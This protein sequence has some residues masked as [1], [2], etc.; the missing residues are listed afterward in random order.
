MLELIAEDHLPQ[1]KDDYEKSAADVDLASVTLFH[2]FQSRR[3]SGA[4]ASTTRIET[5]STK[6][7][8]RFHVIRVLFVRS[9]TSVVGHDQPIVK[10]SVSEQLDYE[11]ELAL[12]IGKPGRHIQRERAW[13]HIFGMTLCNEGASAIGF[14]TGSS[15]SRKG[16]ILTDQDRSGHGLSLRTS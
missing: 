9:P 4:S 16:K 5:K 15:M 13:D 12:V 8:L 6:T 1:V 10:P 7:N 11:G 2:P 14:T 3:K